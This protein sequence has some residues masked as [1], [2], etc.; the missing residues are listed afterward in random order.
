MWENS[1]SNH[2]LDKGFNYFKKGLVENVNIQGNKVT[3]FVQGSQLYKVIIIKE[4]NKII[5]LNCSCP[6]ARGGN[7]C[8]HMVAV[9]YYLEENKSNKSK[10]EE[11]LIRD[12]INNTDILLIKEFLSDLLIN[13]EHLLIS[14][15]KKVM[16][17]SFKTYKEN[18]DDIFKLN[19]KNK[20][21]L[22]EEDIWV[23]IHELSY[24]IEDDAQILINDNDLVGAFKL[25]DYILEKLMPQCSDDFTDTIEIFIDKCLELWDQILI[26][27][28][29]K[30]KREIF[31]TI[32]KKLNDINFEFLLF[33]IE[34][35]MFENFEEKEFNQDKLNYLNKRIKLYYSVAN[36]NYINYKLGSYLL[37]K[38][39][40]LKK[41][42]YTEAE[43]VE[44][45][46]DNVNVFEMRKQYIEYCIDK[47]DYKKAIKL[48][49]EGKQVFAY[50]SN[51]VIEYSH[52][53]KDLYKL[54]GDQDL[55]KAELFEL[56]TIHTKGDLELYKELKSLYSKSEWQKI[57][58]KVFAEISSI[59]KLGDMYVIE[60]LYDKLL[61][62]VLS[63][64]GIYLAMNYVDS[65][66][67][68]DVTK[69]L[70]KY[71]AELN[72]MI[73]NLGTR[74]RYQEIVNILNNMK[75]LPGGEKEVFEIVEV[76]KTKYKNRRALQDELKKV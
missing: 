50:H 40:L 59:S 25:S 49:V 67:D 32:I 24:I 55:Y 64:K 36:F 65:F 66:K 51:V 19:L 38:V 1:F 47:E 56:I 68:L 22:E 2:I 57:R 74:A 45:Y 27:G 42:D 16:P 8:K 29:I 30:L 41:M 10:D 61:K 6:Y 4:D 76:W 21:E 34:K 26:K 31:D 12:L 17:I 37:Q 13:N 70:N 72:K 23:L 71:K 69:L 46:K 39:D 73:E 58:Q 15:K 48:L 54:R 44:V 62:L 60:G 28:D 33:Y 43:I 20:Y 5:D 14:F 9:L 7:Y 11:V 75:R 63:S 3:A 18:V 35:F 53:L 52:W